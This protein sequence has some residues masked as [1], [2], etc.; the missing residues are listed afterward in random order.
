ML[1]NSLAEGVCGA[2]GGAWKGGAM[3][4]ALLMGGWRC[5]LDIVDLGLI[6]PPN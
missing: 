5:K 3:K 6:K 1:I 4:L 2:G